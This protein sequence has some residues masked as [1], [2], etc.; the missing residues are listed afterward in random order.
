ML[1]QGC[2]V[3]FH[4]H[5]QPQCQMCL[6]EHSAKLETQL[7]GTEAVPLWQWRS[8]FSSAPP[9]FQQCLGGYRTTLNVTCAF[10][11][12]HLKVNEYI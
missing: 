7:L 2:D 5:V 1:H 8:T 12:I 9:S 11:S 3:S 6:I 10:L 4:S